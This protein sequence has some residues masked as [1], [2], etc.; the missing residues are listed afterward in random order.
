MLCLLASLLPSTV[1]ITV[2]MMP[3]GARGF[4][5]RN[6]THFFVVIE[7]AV[8]YFIFL[9]FFVDIKYHT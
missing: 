8:I 1:N 9:N 4:I 5:C 7:V 6:G 2:K 3:S